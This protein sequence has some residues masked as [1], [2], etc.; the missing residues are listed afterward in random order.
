MLQQLFFC[1]FFFFWM[2]LQQAGKQIIFNSFFFIQYKLVSRSVTVTDGGCYR[3]IKVIYLGPTGCRTSRINCGLPAW[4]IMSLQS[5]I[6][7]QLLVFCLFIIPFMQMS[8]WVTAGGQFYSSV[9]DRKAVSRFWFGHNVIICCCVF[10]TTVQSVT[11]VCLEKRADE[12]C[13]H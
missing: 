4:L 12:M 10:A 13:Q 6:R 8:D 2:V 7:F 3:L 5:L 1:F 11:S 9:Y